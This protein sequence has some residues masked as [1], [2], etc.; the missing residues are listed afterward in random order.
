VTAK[1]STH[2]QTGGMRVVNVSR[3]AAAAAARKGRKENLVLLAWL[4]QQRIAAGKT[5]R[6]LRMQPTAMLQSD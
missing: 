5:Q 4:L 6:G 3:P 2:G 1:N